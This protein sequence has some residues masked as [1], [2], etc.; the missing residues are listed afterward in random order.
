MDKE[1]QQ[2]KLFEAMLS[3]AIEED[4]ENRMKQF[5]SE[6]ELAK[7]Y[8]LSPE[9]EAR[10]EKT[11]KNYQRKKKVLPMMRIAGKIAVGIIFLFVISFGVL[12]SVEAS[13]V[14]VLNTIMEY[15]KEFIR[16][17]FGE[18]NTDI[19]KSPYR[20]LYIPKG[21]EETE[22]LP[23]GSG[24]TTKYVNSQGMEIIF[25]QT[26]L[27]ESGSSSV[28][29]ENSVYSEI[30]VGGYPG[31]LLEG[32]TESDRTIIIWQNNTYHFKLISYIDKNELLKIAESVAVNQ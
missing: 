21:F 31:D 3:V 1:K 16:F 26:P 32:K 14:H 25:D 27:Q 13:R 18:E 5:P 29:N 20:L 8:P 11:I 17:N 24:F 28:D 19:R 12:M 2:E 23:A 7:A 22:T 30:K 9:F 6:E 15:Q 10:M 4:F